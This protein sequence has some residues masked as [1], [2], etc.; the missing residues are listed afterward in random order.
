MTDDNLHIEWASSLIDAFA[1]AGVADVVLSPGARSTPITLAVAHHA[2]LRTHSI[3]DERSAA[4]FA[5]GIGKATGKPALLVCT[6]GTAGA[7][8]LPAA[9]EAAHSFTPMILLTADRPPELHGN[10]APQ[11]IDQSGLFGVYATGRIELGLPDRSPDSI[12]GIRRKAAQAV[13]LSMSPR[14][15][16]VHLNASFRKPLEPR[17]AEREASAPDGQQ[18]AS[19]SISTAWAPLL[20]PDPAGVETVA[21]AAAASRRALIVCGP[22]PIAQAKTRNA[23][24]RLADIL[25]APLLAEG[26]SQLRFC[27]ER[28]RLRCDGYD[29]FLRSEKMRIP[30]A[31]DLIV[32]IGAPPTSTACREYLSLHREVPRFVI[33]PHGWND[34]DNSAAGLLF[35]AVD[36]TVDR[37]VDHLAPLKIPVDDVWLERFFSADESVRRAIDQRSLTEKDSLS[38]GRLARVLLGHAKN[39]SLLAVGN[40]LPI[41]KVDT[42]CRGE[43]ARAVIL[44]QRGANGI[45]GFL[46]A[47]TGAA[48]SFGG[49]AAVLTGDLAFLHD[50]N[51]LAIAR[52]LETPFVV[53]VAQNRG[54]RIFEKLPLLRSS[55]IDPELAALWTTPQDFDF[56]AAARLFGHKYH[57]AGSVGEMQNALEPAMERPGCTVIEAIVP[58][59]GDDEDERLL[60][61]AEK[62]ASR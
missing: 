45:D 25:H 29:T 2:S 60:L 15:G 13:F 43:N 61:R 41:R 28:N 57:R 35:G 17:T 20:E 31:P 6:S 62:N 55:G 34:P 11:T 14:P 26:A 4:F 8:Y 10:T 49:P 33:A 59:G 54:G 3:I 23:I 5:L 46:S 39:D 30:L 12:R 38:E 52:N 47:A 36:R 48:I 56:S 1:R 9:I 53:V 22:A 32:Q 7:H 50:L 18:A 40:S 21:R 58:Q 19:A 42:W 44:S 27:G 37:L 51:G 24:G 16:A